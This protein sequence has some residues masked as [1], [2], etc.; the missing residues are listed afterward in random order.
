MSTAVHAPPLSVWP[1]Y[2]LCAHVN[3]HE[4]TNFQSFKPKMRPRTFFFFER[5]ATVARI[6][7]AMPISAVLSG[8]MAARRKEK[9]EDKTAVCSIALQG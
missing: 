4:K 9:R 1:P 3:T 6:A 5:V 7:M 8:C 2:C